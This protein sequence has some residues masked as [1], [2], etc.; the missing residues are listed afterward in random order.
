MK[1]KTLII[2]SQEINPHITDRHILYE[3]LFSVTDLKSIINLTQQKD[4]FTV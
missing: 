4:R 2:V 3:L 1:L